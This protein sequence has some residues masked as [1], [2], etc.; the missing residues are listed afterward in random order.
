M[1]S[2]TTSRKGPGEHTGTALTSSS[3]LTTEEYERA[4]VSAIYDPFSAY[5]PYIPSRLT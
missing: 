1:S 5:Q 3:K 2:G 4:G